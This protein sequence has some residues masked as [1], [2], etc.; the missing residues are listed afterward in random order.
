MAI[1]DYTH[2]VDNQPLSPEDHIPLL[3][4]KYSREVLEEKFATFAGINW[5][6]PEVKP[7]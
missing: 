7:L 4:V 5:F 2:E 3:Q 6:N 1:C